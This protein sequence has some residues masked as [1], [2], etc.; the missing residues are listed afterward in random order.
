MRGPKDAKPGTLK[1]V[2]LSDIVCHHAAQ[3]PS[4]MSGVPGVMIEDI[5]LSNMYLQQAGGGDEEVA[6][7]QPPEESN[8][9]PEPAMFGPLPATGF[10][11]RHVRNIQMSNIEIACESGD[12]RPAFWLSDVDGADFFR[13]RVP[14]NKN[15]FSLES[16]KNFRTFGNQFLRDVSEADIKSRR[17]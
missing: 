13:L 16:V 15:A 3:L 5:Q 14:G 4:I 2:I 11:I 1:R 9:Y 8:K 12:V 7:R 6:R 10:F 17:I